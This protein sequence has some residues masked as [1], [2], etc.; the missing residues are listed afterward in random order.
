MEKKTA[1]LKET[2]ETTIDIP[3][4]NVELNEY[5]PLNSVNVFKGLKKETLNMYPGPNHCL[6]CFRCG[7]FYRN[8]GGIFWCS[9]PTV[10]DTTG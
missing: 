10:D 3:P 4:G 7:R 2:A 9:R 8:F 6:I 1:E 5:I